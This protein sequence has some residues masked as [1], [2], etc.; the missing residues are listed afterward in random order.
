MPRKRKAV[1][2]SQLDRI[3]EKVDKVV[4]RVDKLEGKASFWGA[5]GGAATMLVATLAG[6]L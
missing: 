1:T 2:P 3:E 4:A 6:C 5:V